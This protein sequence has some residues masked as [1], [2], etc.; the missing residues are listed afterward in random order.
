MVVKIENIKA[1]R[2]LEETNAQSNLKG[3]KKETNLDLF[4]LKRS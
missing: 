4:S 1:R 3:K 2:A